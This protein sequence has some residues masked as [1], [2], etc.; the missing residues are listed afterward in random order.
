MAYYTTANQ[1][2]VTVSPYI[3]ARTEKVGTSAGQLTD[4]DVGKAVKLS[5]DGTVLCADGDEVYGFIA[6][7]EQTYNG[8]SIA[9]VLSDV[10]HEVI[11]VDEVG[12]L[13]VGD[14]V[15][16]GTKVD[17]GTALTAGGANVKKRT[18]ATVAGQSA[19][20][21]SGALAI[22]NAS[23]AVVK[24]AS[25][26]YALVGGV[27]VSKAASDMAALVGT[28]TAA[29]FNV[30]AFFIDAAGTLTTGMGTEGDTLA[31]VVIPQASSTRAMIGYVI[32]NPTG[33]G[34]FVGGTT[35]LDD[36]TVI[37]NAAYV[38]TIGAVAQADQIV[39]TH[40]WQV[41][42]LEVTP[43]TAGKQVLLRKI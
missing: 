8:Y 37:P 39:G 40:K 21:N 30:F 34:N 7:K 28:V 24:T 6:S 42:G 38:N 10:G 16:A 5:G 31:S 2:Q 43:S 11:A 32:I 20:F 15:V 35:N 3:P 9:G 1:R 29:K 19:V 4:A 27:M 12:G 13:A 33:T 18:G 22:K 41:V 17:F 23:S 26:I 25:T 14:L 36:S